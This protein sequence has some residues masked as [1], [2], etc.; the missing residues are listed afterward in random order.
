MK[1]GTKILGVE[2]LPERSGVQWFTDHPHNPNP[3]FNFTNGAGEGQILS[4]EFL[5]SPE[6]H[7]RYSRF[8][9]DIQ[10]LFVHRLVSDCGG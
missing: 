10:H 5:I 4:F 2:I 7:S 6:F 3:V 8:A 9:H 1:E